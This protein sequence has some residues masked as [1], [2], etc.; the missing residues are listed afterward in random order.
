MPGHPKK[1]Q[2]GSKVICYMLYSNYFYTQLVS[3][4]V[5]QKNFYVHDNT[6]AVLL[7]PLQ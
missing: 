7:F 6:D 2:S 1:L 4:F 5:P 3:G